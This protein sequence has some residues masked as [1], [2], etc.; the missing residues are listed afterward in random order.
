MQKVVGFEEAAEEIGTGS[1]VAVLGVIGWMVP[2]K[3]LRALGDRFER[4]GQPSDLTLYVPCAAGDNAEI[5]GMDH[6]VRN[7]MTRRLIT[8]SFINPPDPKTGERPRTMQLVKA[9]KI[10]AYTFHIGAMMHWLREI[11]R[12][13]PGYITEVGI[14]T[15]VDPDLGGGKV[16]PCTQVDI[17]EK[18]DF[19][20]KEYLFFPSIHLDHGIIRATASD[21][22]GNLSFEDDPLTSSSLAI[23]LAVKAC[24][25]TVI[26]Q[27]KRIV[28]P[29]ERHAH[30]IK[31]PG[32]LIDK[33][34]VDPDQWLVTGIK[35]DPHFLGQERIVPQNMEPLAM[36]PS[37]IIA[38]RS[39]TLIKKGELSIYGFGAS[40]SIPSIFAE[41][42]L[43]DGDGLYDYPST[44][45]H[46]SY[47]GIVTSGWQFSA[48][49]NPDALIDGVTQFD[50]IHGGLCKT[51]ALAFAQFDEAGNVNVS[52]FA[53]ANPGSGGF[54]D[55]AHNAESLI[56]N[57]TFTTGGLQVETGNG[58]LKIVQEG[59]VSK[60]VKAAEQITYPVL[61]GVRE[62]GQTA[63]IVTE[64]A[65]FS[66]TR[67]GLALREVAP[68]IDPKSEVLDLMEYQPTHIPDSIPKM[69][70]ELFR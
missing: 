51:A 31:V 23:A 57:G 37:K 46:G 63:H 24:G 32:V 65:V 69:D 2:D 64:R 50:A 15:F 28:E 3:M 58:T 33:V 55:I 30:M 38:R 8:G 45:E 42:G 25:G 67:E 14:G 12:R 7:G 35:D 36:G 4:A 40:S 54:I 34:V 20:G 44:T 48:N 22:H 6:I 39:A 47:G 29:G 17:V 61:Q 26:A 66:V 9:D 70:S 19:R 10:E 49:L 68:G 27:V 21:I 62:R 59:K 43:F 13:S 18:I 56:F 16:T 41:D 11:A 5:K 60:F 53:N 1:T 52:K